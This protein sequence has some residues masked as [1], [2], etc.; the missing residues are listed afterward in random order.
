MRYANLVRALEA[1]YADAGFL[2][3][4]LGLIEEEVRIGRLCLPFPVA[5]GAWTSHAYRVVFRG[6]AARR[7]QVILFRSWLLERSSE[8][9]AQ[10]RQQVAG[11]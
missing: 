8:T 7:A 1:I 4:G 11:T 5:Q 6:S 9:R 10:L 2:I 3:C